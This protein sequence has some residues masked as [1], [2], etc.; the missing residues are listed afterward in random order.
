MGGVLAGGLKILK[1]LSLRQE[2][3]FA[4]RGNALKSRR[5]RGHLSLRQ[6]HLGRKIHMEGKTFAG[7][8]LM[9]ASAKGSLAAHPR[10][11]EHGRRN[12]INIILI[13]TNI[14]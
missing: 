1:I 6:E 9:R 13:Y 10:F 5:D 14:Y 3:T 2:H 12:H 8:F 7:G 4:Q 11:R